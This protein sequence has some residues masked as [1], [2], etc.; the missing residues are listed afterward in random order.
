MFS[1]LASVVEFSNPRQPKEIPDTS[2]F[3]EIRAGVTT[4]ATM[5]YI[6]A[7]NVSIY[8]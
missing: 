4:F 1:L 3:R 7:V 2:F 6:I 5:A 8:L